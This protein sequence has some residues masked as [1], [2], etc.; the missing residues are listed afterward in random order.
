MKIL[1]I[2]NSH[3]SKGGA[4]NVYFNTANLLS[5]NGHEVF[6]F[7]VND[8][9]N[10]PC[11]NSEYFI[12][13]NDYRNSSLIEKIRSIP[14]FIYN[15]EANVK[16]LNLIDKVKPDIAHIHLFLGG[17]TT[18]IL[19]AL[20][21]RN[22][23]IVHSV[24]DYRL[25]CPAYTF[26]DRN[27]QI[28]ERC[29]DKLFL[30]CAIRRCSL[31]NNIIHSTILSFDAYFREYIYNPLNYIDRFV[32][33]SQ[34]SKKKHIEFN[35]FFAKKAEVLYNFNNNQI[36]PSKVRGNYFL[37]FG[38]HSR[39]KGLT[40]L[41]ETAHKI[42]IPLKVCG[43]GPL[44]D[45]LKSLN[46]RNIEFLG[47]IN[48]D[49]LKNVI[50]NSSFIIVPSECYENNPLTIIEAFT[51]G[52]PVIGSKIGGITELIGDLNGLLFESK[53][54]DSLNEVIIK[55]LS[56]TDSEYLKMSQNVCEFAHENFSKEVHYKKLLEIYK[57]VIHDKKNN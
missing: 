11:D 37:F 42:N 10:R 43:A 4:D 17:L 47:H 44:T 26:L 6:F 22:I 29:K 9:N 50:R 57:S 48:N 52:K 3:Y 1:L 34:F 38:R 33:T 13:K 41:I 5:Q 27:N 53:N 7:S 56:I 30:K 31:E 55:A 24:H 8:P 19:I 21:K 20:K 25:I 32:F 35:S 2:N 15:R 39:E 14:S 12:K 18:S 23:P 40:L 45:K 28:C 16:L 54:A 51:F 46:Y 49:E 36:I